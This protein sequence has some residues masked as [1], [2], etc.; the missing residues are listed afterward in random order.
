M[1]LAGPDGNYSA[2]SPE[3]AMLGILRGVGG[4]FPLAAIL[5]K[6]LSRLSGILGFR[7]PA[8]VFIHFGC[9]ASCR[10]VGSTSSPVVWYGLLSLVSLSLLSHL[11]LLNL[12]I[13]LKVLQPRFGS[14]T[15]RSRPGGPGG[16]TPHGRDKSF[17]QN[18]SCPGGESCADY[19]E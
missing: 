3:K 2:A 12:R 9:W 18:V 14:C 11:S 7:P 17:F 19:V 5:K 6:L 4:D 8:I 13:F 10:L 15:I 16:E 1:L